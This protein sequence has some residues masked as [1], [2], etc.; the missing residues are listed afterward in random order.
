VKSADAQRLLTENV[1][2]P[3][4]PETGTLLHLSRGQ[5]YRAAMDGEIPTVA[6]AKIRRVPTA[7]LRQVLGIEAESTTQA[8]VD[9][10]EAA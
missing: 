5:A 4:W 1:V 9:E 10:P 6:I 8:G 7:W 3:L 2:L